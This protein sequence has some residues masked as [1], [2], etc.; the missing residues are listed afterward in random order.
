MI[1]G[2]DKCGKEIAYGMAR[3]GFGDRLLL[4]Y[5]RR[6]H[7]DIR[8][9][10]A[11][12]RTDVNQELRT[13]SFGFLRHRYPSVSL[14]TDFPN[15][16]VMDCYINPVCS[17]K[18]G[19]AGGSGGGPMRGSGELNLAGIAAF[20]EEK[21]GEWGYTNKILYRFRTLLWPAALIRILRCAALEA[22]ER[23][24]EKRLAT[25]REDWAIVGSLQ[26]SQA[27]AVGT[28]ASLV[29]RHLGTNDVDRR[30]AAFVNK[31]SALPQSHEPMRF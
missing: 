29:K 6:A 17:G 20:C 2:V 1:Q 11:H 18:V 27:E 31:G 4:I 19:R 16:Q 28:P 12:W 8:P 25:G 3:C 10:L 24:R 26:P 14:P 23:E 22:D 30:A 15:L 13:N 9:A 21:F 5:Q 7:E